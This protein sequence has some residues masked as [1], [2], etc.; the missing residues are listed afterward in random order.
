MIVH[1]FDIN[2]EVNLNLLHFH[3]VFWIIMFVTCTF[4]L[5]YNVYFIICI[6]IKDYLMQNLYNCI[7]TLCLSRFYR[8]RVYTWFI[9]ENWKC[10]TDFIFIDTYKNI[11]VHTKYTNV[12]KYYTY[13]WIFM[14]LAFRFHSIPWNGMEPWLRW[15]RR[16]TERLREGQE[17]WPSRHGLNRERV[18]FFL[19]SIRHPTE[20]RL[21][22]G[23]YV[24][25]LF[26]W[27]SVSFVFFLFLVLLSFESL[28]KRVILI[29]TAF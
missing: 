1:I 20:L 15:N 23:I 7:A 29:D 18:Y 12:F 25:R 28:F 24:L 3:T 13:R 16:T 26:I 22:N 19:T 17:P 2:F 27:S 11:H 21:W 10:N 14:I 9:Y 6:Q 5:W 4:L 8:H